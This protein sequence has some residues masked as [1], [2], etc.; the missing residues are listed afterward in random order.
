MAQDPRTTSGL[1]IRFE[2]AA[3][4]L[5]RYTL[6]PGELLPNP[7]VD[8][9][10]LHEFRVE[11][12]S[13]R[14]TE[15]TPPIRAALSI[16]RGPVALIEQLASC[17]GTP[18]Y[19]HV[20]YSA[21]VDFARYSE[22]IS[23]LDRRDRIPPVADSFAA[24]FGRPYGGYRSVIEAVRCDDRTAA[25]LAV[26]TGSTVLMREMTMYDMEGISRHICWT[27]YRPDLT[28]IVAATARSRRPA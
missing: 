28:A 21:Q 17:G 5:P 14:I 18:V 8:P 20:G 25:M 16:G 24:L 4:N 2:R 12:M 13:H 26:E 11:E 19:L 3:G 9:D 23:A 6:H 10:L 22:T 27:H 1:R 15:S 7:L